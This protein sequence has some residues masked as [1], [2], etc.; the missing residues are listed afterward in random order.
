VWET[1]DRKEQEDANDT[2]IWRYLGD[3][4]ECLGKDGMSSEDSNYEPDIG[5]FF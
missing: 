3:M 4:L 1:I 5:Q 2:N